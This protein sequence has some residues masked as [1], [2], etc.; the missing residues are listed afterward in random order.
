M[1]DNAKLQE[2][3][4]IAYILDLENKKGVNRVEEL[5]NNDLKDLKKTVDDL[6]K[7]I[8]TIKNNFNFSKGTKIY[9]IRLKE[10]KLEKAN[11][12]LNKEIENY[13]RFKKKD[14]QELIQAEIKFKKTKIEY[15]DKEEDNEKDLVLETNPL[16]IEIKEE[17]AEKRDDLREI[18]KKLEKYRI[19]SPFDGIIT[20]NEYE[21]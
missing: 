18:E 13:K 2:A 10:I 3:N 17:V 19:I 5:L 16:Y 1:K 8:E 6:R 15:M 7:E 14:K 12:D 20:K 11:I 4:I 9:N 21:L